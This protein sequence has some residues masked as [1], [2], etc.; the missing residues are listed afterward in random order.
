MHT[1][2]LT[3]KDDVDLHKTD[4]SDKLKKMDR[5]FLE[6]E[7]IDEHEIIAILGPRDL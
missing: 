3:L 6:R 4:K 7:K 2:N 1:R 5:E